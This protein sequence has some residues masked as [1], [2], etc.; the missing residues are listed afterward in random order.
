[1]TGLM[2]DARNEETGSGSNLANPLG[3]GAVQ[4]KHQVVDGADGIAIVTRLDSPA[5]L[6]LITK[7]AIG[8]CLKENDSIELQHPSEANDEPTGAFGWPIFSVQ[9]VHGTVDRGKRR[10]VKR[11]ISGGEDAPV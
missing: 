2:D 11:H 7:T 10:P 6:H 3:A 5:N 4:L 8:A 9:A 1:M